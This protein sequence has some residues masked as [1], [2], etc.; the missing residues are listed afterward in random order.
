[1]VLACTGEEDGGIG[2]GSMTPTQ[3][4]APCYI[5]INVASTSKKKRSAPILPLDSGYDNDDDCTVGTG[6]GEED[7]GTDIYD[8]MA[9]HLAQA[10]STQ[11]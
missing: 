1:M 11:P 5:C 7:G 2:L 8:V 6:A 10:S 9:E 3:L 4:E